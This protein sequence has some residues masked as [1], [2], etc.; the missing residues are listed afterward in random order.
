[1]TAIHVTSTSTFAGKTAVC[2][3]L[4]I[5]LIHDGIPF[6]YLKPITRAARVLEGKL[7]DE[8]AQFIKETFGLPEPAEDLT[9]VVITPQ[10]EEAILRGVEKTDFLTRIQEGLEAV[11]RSRQVIIMEAGTS[12][13]EGYLLGL[14][15]PVLSDLLGSRE[16]VVVRHSDYFLDE[17]LIACDM[18]GPS[19]IGV[20][21]NA[22]PRSQMERVS[23]LVRPYLE[24]RGVPVLGLLPQEQLL[25][26][27]SVRDLA[28]IL[29]GEIICCN[30]RADDLVEHLM[31]GAMS[32]ETALGYFRRKPNKAVI[33]GGDRPD[34]Q[35]A[36]LETSTRCLILT[37]NLRPSDVIL[38]RAAEVRVPVILVDYDTL[39][40]IRVIEGS[41]GKTRFHQQ[42]KIQRF[43]RLFSQGFDFSRLFEILDLKM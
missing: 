5:Q 8:D 23:T 10:V 34:I 41:F 15:T 17:I 14:P 2:V 16:L 12:L 36:A 31:V 42:K 40:T 27:V 39:T 9:P 7:V 43:V 35:L 6:G 1:M 19:L 25:Q 20:V 38:E 4:G 11:S 21:V 13:G 30:D 26:S 24:G 33:T 32:A 18:L 22:I 29:Q 37:G 3:G 28:D